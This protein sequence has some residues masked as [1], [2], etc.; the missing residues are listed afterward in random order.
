MVTILV[1]GGILIVEIVPLF[2]LI[3][4]V[5]CELPTVCSILTIFVS[6]AGLAK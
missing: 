2:F 1:D 5:V 6:V 3:K 4:S